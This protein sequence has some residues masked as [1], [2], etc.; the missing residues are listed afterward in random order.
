MVRLRRLGW[1]SR[2]LMV[3]VLTNLNASQLASGTVP[4]ARVSGSTRGHGL[5]TITVGTWNGTAL[6]DAFVSDTL[7]CVA[8]RWLGSTTTAIDLP[9]AEV[10][11]LLQSLT[12]ELA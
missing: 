6:T 3:S 7:D 4:A 1:I 11:G 2:R 8:V 12:E 5:G 9:T 10:N